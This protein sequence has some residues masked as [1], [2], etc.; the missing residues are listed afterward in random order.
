MK[1]NEVEQAIGITKK[2]IRFYEE[3][4]LL[5]PARNASNG[6]RDYSARDLEVLGQ[7]KLLRKLGIPIEEIRR[8]QSRRLTL[9]DCL[10]RHM[11]VLERESQNLASVRRFCAGLREQGVTLDTL[12]PEKLLAQ[13]KEMEEGGTRFMDIQNKDKRRRKKDALIA[14]ASILV[15]QL[16]VLG[17][18]LWVS[19]LAEEPMPLPVLALLAGVLALTAGGILLALRERFKEIEGGE[20]DEASKY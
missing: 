14:A 13:M 5:A 12:E 15:F 1:I 7:I 2:N 17:V 8:L 6:Y 19:H 11:V 4:G 18:C 10:D 20:L 3:Q 9:T 16:A